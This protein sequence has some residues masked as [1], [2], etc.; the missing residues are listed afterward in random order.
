MTL[1]PIVDLQE[2]K[3]K[4]RIIRK[5]SIIDETQICAGNGGMDTCRVSFYS[6]PF[7]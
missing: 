6:K 1:L 3:E 4:Y 2:C 5:S 7:H